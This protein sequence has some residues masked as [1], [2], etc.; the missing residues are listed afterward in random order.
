[1]NNKIGVSSVVYD[2]FGANAAFKSVA[3]N[4]FKF[5]EITYLEGFAENILKRPEEMT[6]KDIGLMLALA[7]NY[8]I[9]IYAIAVY[10]YIIQK[11]AVE[12]FKNIIDVANSLGAYTIITDTGDAK[13]GEY[14]KID[15]FYKNIKNIARYAELKNTNICFE[16]HGGLCSTGKQGVEIVK[17][18]DHPNIRLNYDT[19][20]VIYFG[21]ERPEDDIIG[22]SPYFGFMHLKEKAGKDD[23]FNFPAIGDG[24]IDFKKIFELIKDYDGSIS[25]EVELTEEKYSLDEVN[26]AYKKSYDFVR[27]FGFDI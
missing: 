23:E 12:N 4:G 20:N 11:N 13:E 1:M 25:L 5:I 6:K 19:A 24:N 16:I 7:K 10:N 27:S 3:D 8:N 14:D 2:P 17:K 9:N 22:L 18:I 26:I 21:G 15:L